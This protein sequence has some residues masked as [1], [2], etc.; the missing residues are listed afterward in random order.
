M[1]DADGMAGLN[2]STFHRDFG[3]DQVACD[4]VDPH[5]RGAADGVEHVAADPLAAGQSG[6]TRRCPAVAVG[7]TAN[8]V[9]AWYG[10]EAVAGVLEWPVCVNASSTR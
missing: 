9:Q 8:D 3:L 10:I 4:P 1:S 6:S 2:V 5:A 7:L